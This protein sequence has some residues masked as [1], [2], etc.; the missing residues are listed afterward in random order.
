MKETVRAV[1]FDMDGVLLDTERLCFACFERAGGERGLSGIRAV[2]RRCMGTGTA[3]M[4]SVLREVYGADFDARGFYDRVMELFHAT[5]TEQGLPLMPQVVPCLRALRAAGYRLAVA[6]STRTA[7]VRRQLAAAGILDFFETTTCGD[8][9]AHAK[10]APDIYLRACASLALPP[11]ACVAVED[12]FNGVRAACAAGISCVMVPDQL[13]P[14]DEIRD[15]A[16]V[17]LDDL[18][19]LPPWLAAAAS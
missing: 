11:A 15:L 1:I 3:D 16:A 14:T 4:F 10:P 2:Y 18:G 5:E 9:V 17:V 8:T 19:G 13:P 12:S 6:S 7:T